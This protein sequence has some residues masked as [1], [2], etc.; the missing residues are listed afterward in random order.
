MVMVVLSRALLLFACPSERVCLPVCKSRVGQPL[1]TAIDDDLLDTK[2]SDEWST[3]RAVAGRVIW[4]KPSPVSD[5]DVQVHEHDRGWRTLSF[6]GSTFGVQSV[7]KVVNG[8]VEP[9]AIANDYLKTMC[10][11]AFS[12]TA[13]SEHM[14]GAAAT[15]APMRMLFLGMGGG[16]LPTLLCHHLP[17]TEASLMQAVEFDSAVADAARECLGLDARVRVD[18]G[19]AYQWIRDH[20]ARLASSPGVS[21]DEPPS[22]FDAIFVDIFDGDNLTPAAFYS[23]EFLSAVRTSLTPRG[24]VVHNMH[25]GGAALDI[26]LAQ[27][28]E[29]YAR[30]FPPGSC[31]RIPALRRGNTVVAAAA[32]PGLFAQPDALVDAASWARSRYDLLFDAAGRCQG[33]QPVAP[34]QCADLSPM[35]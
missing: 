25:S 12:A 24:V 29:A 34:R 4:S 14:S 32:T 28:S 16:T 26:N 22:K 7:G 11:V 33:L 3:F 1:C 20:A 8:C 15:S 13:T 18:V 35:K 10:A 5:A 9:R 31:A 19:D 27:A 2:F 30:A 23:A 6:V 17:P 21:P